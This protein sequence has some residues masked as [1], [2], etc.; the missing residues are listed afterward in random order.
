MFNWKSKYNDRIV[1]AE[2]AVQHINSGDRV[3]VGH[4][5]GEPLTIVEA[6][7]QRHAELKNV[8]IFHMVAMGKAKYTQPGMEMSFRHNAAFLGGS[9]RKGYAE[10][11]VDYTPCFLSEVP[12]MFL[13][14]YL[15]VDVALVTVTPPDEEGKCSFG[16]SVDFTEPAARAAKTVIAQFNKYMPRTNGPTIAI[17]DID[18]IV[19]LDE[20]LIEL[21][22]PVITKVEEEIGKNVAEL[23]PD[24]ATLQLGIGGIPDAVL[25]F[26]TEKKNLGIHTEMF[27]DG[28]VALAEMGVVTNKKK[29]LHPGKYIATFFMGTKKLYDFVDNNPDLIMF[30]CSYTNDPSVIAQ[31]NLMVSINSA[32]QVDLMGQ[33]NA[34]SIGI[35]QFSGVGGQV[36]FVRG[37]SRSKGGKSILGLPSTAANGTKS[38]IVIKLDDYSA[39]TT[40]RNDVRFIVTEYGVAELWPKTLSQRAEALIAIAHPKFR[41]ELKEQ[42]QKIGLLR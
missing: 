19:E 14:G 28:V 4:C 40:S 3:V 15:P 26:L 8:E 10:R 7:V 42:A 22:P 24:E 23:I 2:E 35:N 16:V 32:L 21:Q 36:D 31:N 41:D 5:C 30:D 20:P 17:S 37:S 13:E 9:T 27:S 39:I 11:R 29:T 38:R 6:M 1:T 34:E 25:H 18:W 33:V 12:K